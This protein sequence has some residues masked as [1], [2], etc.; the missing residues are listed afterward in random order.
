MIPIP[1]LVGQV[2]LK[3]VPVLKDLMEAIEL[4]GY[5][6]STKRC[7]EIAKFI[8]EQSMLIIE[9]HNNE[10]P[11]KR[12]RTKYDRVR[13]T[14][15]IQQDYMGP[16]AIF[17]DKQFKRMFRMSE[18]IYY[19]IK[20]FA[21]TSP[22]FAL[23]D[24]E[25]TGRETICLDAR[26]LISLKYLA[27]GIGFNAFRDYFQMGQT[28]ARSCFYSF[29]DLLFSNEELRA[30][31]CRAMSKGDAKR[32][33]ALHKRVHGVPGMLGSLDCLHVP[34]KNCPYQWQGSWKGK[35]KTPTIAIEAACDANPWFWHATLGHPGAMNDIN[36]F[37]L[38]TISTKMID[39]TLDDIDEPF[40]INGEQF[41]MNYF[42]ADGIYPPLARI[43][44]TIP[45]ATTPEE[46]NFQGWQESTRQDIERAFGVL[47]RRFMILDKSIELWEIE[48]IIKVMYVCILLHNMLVEE[49]E[50]YDNDAFFL[51]HENEWNA[52][53]VEATT[54]SGDDVEVAP[55][56]QRCRELLI[57][58]ENLDSA[59]KH[60]ENS[61][62][63]R[64]ESF[65][66]RTEL[67]LERKYRHLYDRDEHNRLQHALMTELFDRKA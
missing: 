21:S 44:K 48:Q 20:Q 13:A 31:Y 54:E 22:L 64:K 67:L 37:D 29:I 15:C 7:I 63:Q 53:E 42:L 49:K 41:T 2:L 58:Q 56:V 51:L 17:N 27:Y 12:R 8:T 18:S 61:L 4:Y 25:P 35:E 26:L 16:N 57:Q 65:K 34:W 60:V 47:I 1:I 66:S 32:V 5:S 10:P 11:K 40:E 43:V 28:T 39:G 6:S 24:F 62:K 59:L 55:H 9:T 52:E 50:R 36:I 30:Y 38:S 45:I 33:T 3:L 23:N 19:R 46:K 14:L